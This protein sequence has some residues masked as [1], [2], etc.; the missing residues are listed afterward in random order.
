MGVIG[1]H[2][3]QISDLGR[4]LLYDALWR[5]NDAMGIVGAVRVTWVGVAD[6]MIT[7]FSSRLF[8]C[9]WEARGALGGGPVGMYGCGADILKLNIRSILGQHERVISRLETH[10]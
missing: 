1:G 9:G 4:L 2:S 6:E 5:S 10:T 3:I 7:P 8:F